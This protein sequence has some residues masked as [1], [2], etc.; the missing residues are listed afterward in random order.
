MD[1]LIKNICLNNDFSKSNKKPDI[2]PII[3]LFENL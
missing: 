2:F 3:G 1:G